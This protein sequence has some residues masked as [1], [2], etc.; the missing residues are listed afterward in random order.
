MANENL[1]RITVNIN[2]SINTPQ[3]AARSRRGFYIG[4]ASKG[5]A[6]TSSRALSA[7]EV[8]RAFG[9]SDVARAAIEAFSS[10][11]DQAFIYR[12]LST[13]GSIA[14]IGSP[15][16]VAGYSLTSVDEGTD[17]MAQFKVLYDNSNDELTI[18][19][20]SGGLIF[21]S[22]A[23]AV[24]TD[25]S[26]VLVEGSAD[27]GSTV[28][29]V[30]GS[31]GE[32]V[33]VA[34]SELTQTFDDA[35]LVPGALLGNGTLV[36]DVADGLNL[37]LLQWDA[38]D[39]P[40]MLQIAANDGSAIEEHL[41]TGIDAANRIVTFAGG[42]S[43]GGFLGPA[44][45]NYRFVSLSRPIVASS[46]IT[47]RLGGATNAGS[48]AIV[49]KSGSAYNGLAPLS[50]AGGQAWD[51]SVDEVDPSAMALYEGLWDAGL[52]LEGEE[53][54]QLS[55]AG[56]YL[57]SP[58]LDGQTSG[59][60][61][62]PT[63]SSA[64]I[65]DSG[66]GNGALNEN[67]TLT[68]VAGQAR[69]VLVTFADQPTR[70]AATIVLNAA[71]R[72]LPKLIIDQP[73]DAL[74]GANRNSGELIRTASVLN[75]ED[76]AAVTDILLHLDADL[77]L[78]LTVG[79]AIDGGLSPEFRVIST[80][81]LFFHR[82]VEVDGEPQHQW[83]TDKNGPDGF[84]FNEV[85]PA[86]RLANICRDLFS[87]GNFAQGV[88]GIRPPTNHF[89]TAA[90]ARWM[91]KGPER[92]SNTGFITK[93]GSGLLGNKFIAG[94]ALNAVYGGVNDFSAGFFATESGYLSG[95]ILRDQGGVVQDLGKYLLVCPQ[96][97]RQT[98][99][100]DTGA[101]YIN[102]SVG[103]V[104]GLQASLGSDTPLTNK[105][106]GSTG[107][108]LTSPRFFN[109]RRLN[110]IA[111]ARCI[112]IGSRG[113]LIV[114]LSSPTFSRGTSDYRQE[115]TMRFAGDIVERVRLTA[116]PFLGGRVSV[117]TLNSMDSSIRST[118]N[119]IRLATGGAL[120]GYDFSL[121]TDPALLELGCVGIILALD[122][123]EE[124]TKISIQVSLGAVGS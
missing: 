14:G 46:I 8:S 32:Q 95:T 26:Q 103:L 36:V 88:I 58:A 105:I 64:F 124:L 35:N 50:V 54:D 99:V 94:K 122:F 83:Y 111:G 86:Y 85:N 44:L 114:P 60:T 96:W 37:N 19:N 38:T 2:D 13:P 74:F 81:L 56:L 71:G 28:A 75:W 22:T 30:F 115:S 18:Y 63:A 101:G 89:S 59:E 112:A 65:F 116:S 52:D 97:L 9:T 43:A 23:S 87:E 62:L 92:S 118:L 121:D 61:A 3:S 66:S 39:N 31:V 20:L 45:N 24:S 49:L 51:T 100:S 91:G 90:L 55:I 10:G 70:D 67:L 84:H 1:A 16:G 113:G 80:D 47:N 57:D 110:L 76:G 120:R 77:G 107:V 25:F 4:T 69:Q 5:P 33:A 48:T 21:K 102:S 7:S 12:I 27:A 78:S 29:G 53:L 104:A 11:A 98:N 79:G 15:T 68:T 72:R 34:T 108:A 17:A 42:V 40:Y 41:V 117:L 123:A 119:G 6:R 106:L 82:A 109:R 93:N 73:K